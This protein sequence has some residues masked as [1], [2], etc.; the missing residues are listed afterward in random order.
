MS[1]KSS[2][3]SYILFMLNRRDYSE[4]ELRQKLSNKKYY[5][6]DIVN[7]VIERFKEINYISD[8]RCVSTLVRMSYI[9]LYGINKIKEK[10]F[11]RGLD[12]DSVIDECNNYDFFESCLKFV[13]KKLKDRKILNEYKEKSKFINKIIGRGFVYEQI[14][15][16]IEQILN[17]E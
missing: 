10:A 11:K 9:D 12:I 5:D 6:E 8:E 2:I 15:Y 13:E 7:E 4:S 17:I 3:E 16:A 1:K 14:N